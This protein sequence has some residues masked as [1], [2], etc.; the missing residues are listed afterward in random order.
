MPT[1]ASERHGWLR[2]ALLVGVAYVVVGRVFALPGEHA[3]LW[4]LAA[5]LVSGVA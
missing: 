1:H 4:R 2:A 5:W 3:R